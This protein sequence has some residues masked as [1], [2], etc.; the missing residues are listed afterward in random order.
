MSAHP[1][2]ARSPG[3]ASTRARPSAATIHD[4]AVSHVVLYGKPDC[5]LCDEVS[6]PAPLA[7]L[8]RRPLTTLDA[9]LDVAVRA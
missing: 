5:M 8:L 2:R 6:D 3:A 9:A 1:S 7:G 4:R